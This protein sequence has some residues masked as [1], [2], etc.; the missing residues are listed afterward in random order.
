MQQ[1]LQHDNFNAGH[2]AKLLDD[3]TTSTN[4]H[5]IGTEAIVAAGRGTYI[6]ALGLG[7][8]PHVAAV[9]RIQGG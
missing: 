3:E 7:T 8:C 6:T 9:T 4:N 1:H 5:Q 2:K